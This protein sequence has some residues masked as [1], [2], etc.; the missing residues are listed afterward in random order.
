MTAP[1]GHSADFDIIA[2]AEEGNQVVGHRWV[3]DASKLE[4]PLGQSFEHDEH[5]AIAVI[6]EETEALVRALLNIDHGV[7]LVQVLVGTPSTPGTQLTAAVER[8]HYPVSSTDEIPEF[9]FPIWN[10]CENG[11]AS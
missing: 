9:K 6:F 1:Q 3:I 10:S 5:E 11:P 2:L 8:A 4:V 7:Q